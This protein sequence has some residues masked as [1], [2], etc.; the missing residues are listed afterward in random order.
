RAPTPA[1]FSCADPEA[2][3]S[4]TNFF[5]SDPELK[6][7][8]AHTVEAGLRGA[9]QWNDSTLAWQIGAYRSA[10]EDEIQF[11]A[12]GLTGRGFFQNID[13]P[14][15]QGIDV[16]VDLASTRWSA[17]LDYS[18]TE[19]T[20]RSPLLLNSPENPEADDNG[21]IQVVPGDQF[22]SIPANVVKAV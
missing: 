6:Q 19:A 16:S 15:R 18:Y 3:C 10:I 2:P 12:S 7:V 9:R 20:F 17:A 4:L 14:R 5:V 1:E 8:V 21:Q 13:K 11:V 22:P